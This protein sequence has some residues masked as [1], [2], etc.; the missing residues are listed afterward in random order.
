MQEYFHCVV[1]PLD[2]SSTT[3]VWKFDKDIQF[4]IIYDTEKHQFIINQQIFS[5]A[6]EAK[7]LATLKNLY[8]QCHFC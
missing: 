2:T 8:F 1:L 5:A 7:Q 6:L 4:T 3:A